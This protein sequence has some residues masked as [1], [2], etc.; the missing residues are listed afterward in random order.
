MEAMRRERKADHAKRNAL[1][2]GKAAAI[3]QAA[4]PAGDDHAYLLNKGVKAHGVRLHGGML[5]IPMR[6]GEE[7]YSLQFIANDGQ[8]RFLTDGRVGGCYFFIDGESNGPLCIA[9]GYATGASIH[10]ATG[11]SI[12]VAFNAGN[13][14]PV[15]REMLAQYPDRRLTICADDD[16]KTTGNPGLTK[17]REAAQAVGGLLA[18]P[19]FG[20]DRPKDATDFNDLHRY[21]GLPA[22]RAAIERAVMVDVATVAT[23]TVA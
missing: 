6:T 16:A 2:R 17:G 7:L 1:A 15:A 4:T 12:A 8:K 20:E 19:N 13:L 3:W 22:V 18:I 14:L 21:V 10:E 9:E 5:V 23:A 11:Y